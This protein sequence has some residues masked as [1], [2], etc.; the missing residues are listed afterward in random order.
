MRGMGGT[1][2]AEAHEGGR[3]HST[4]LG[5]VHEDPSERCGAHEVDEERGDEAK[6][7]G[8]VGVHPPL[9]CPRFSLSFISFLSLLL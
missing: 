2:G 9:L 7:D 5:R 1:V 6:L 4:T 8:R 3:G